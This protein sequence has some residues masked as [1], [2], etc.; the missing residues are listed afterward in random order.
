MN[1]KIYI[2]HFPPGNSHI[3][4]LTRLP[5]IFLNPKQTIPVQRPPCSTRRLGTHP[6]SKLTANDSKIDPTRPQVPSRS[7]M[8]P[9][10]FPKFIER[11]P[12][13]FQHASKPQSKHP[14]MKTQT[15]IKFLN[16]GTGPNPSSASRVRHI[17][18]PF[19]STTNPDY[20][21]YAR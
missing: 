6:N 12:P 17:N 19:S 2:A 7:K 5:T 21:H 10:I 1:C 8:A 14:E 3:T 13:K 15:L 11:K 9:Q 4:V 16:R 20:S 18:S